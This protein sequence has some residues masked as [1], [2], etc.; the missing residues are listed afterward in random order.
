MSS[1]AVDPIR[2]PNIDRADAVTTP[3]VFSCQF[4]K[5]IKA[6]YGTGTDLTC[7]SHQNADFTAHLQQRV[8]NT[9]WPGTTLSPMAGGDGTWG[10]DS[11]RG[12]GQGGDPAYESSK[13]LRVSYSCVD[14]CTMRQG[15]D[16]RT[17]VG[18][19]CAANP[20]DPRETKDDAADPATFMRWY[21]ISEGDLKRECL[22]AWSRIATSRASGPVAGILKS[23]D[24]FYLEPS[25]TQISILG[26][27]GRGNNGAIYVIKNPTGQGPEQVVLKPQKLAAEVLIRQAEFHKLQEYTA[28]IVQGH[29]P[30]IRTITPRGFDAEGGIHLAQPR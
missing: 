12:Y 5:I 29:D 8:E 7:P 9:S 22:L 14:G 15:S 10:V 20:N 2:H 17:V 3:L 16:C 24:Q 11:Y 19:F 27:L 26:E 21:T 1:F 6:C 28:M 18:M 13:N 23:M 4:P 25:R 30:Y